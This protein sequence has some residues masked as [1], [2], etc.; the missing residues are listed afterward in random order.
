MPTGTHKPAE[1]RN[2]C[3]K[4]CIAIALDEVMTALEESFCDLSD[5]QVWSRPIAERHSIGT[6][7]MHCIPQLNGLACW[8]QTG[9]AVA[10]IP[11]EDGGP[12]RTPRRQRDGCAAPAT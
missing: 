1:A 9:D 8:Q 5:Q 4:D 10:G 11:D 6:M 2:R 7:L 12:G 3:W